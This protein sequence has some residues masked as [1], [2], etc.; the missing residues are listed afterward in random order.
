LTSIKSALRPSWSLP[1]SGSRRRLAVTDV[2]D[3]NAS[4]GVKPER[5]TYS[6]SSWCSDAPAITPLRWFEVSVPLGGDVSGFMQ[7]NGKYKLP[8][9]FN[10]GSFKNSYVCT[11]SLHGKALATDIETTA[12]MFL[13]ALGQAPSEPFTAVLF[14][15]SR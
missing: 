10:S 8:N 3:C 11:C 7:E 6:Q 14:L 15:A 4:D 12:H 1:R 9:D 5:L 2:A 13:L